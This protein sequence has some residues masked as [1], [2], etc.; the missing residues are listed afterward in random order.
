MAPNPSE[1]RG[2]SVGMLVQGMLAGFSAS[3]FLF[4]KI[5]GL[6]DD[7]GSV[8]FVYFRSQNPRSTMIANKGLHVSTW[9]G[10]H[11]HSDSFKYYG[12]K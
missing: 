3:P 10:Y 2:L 12:R 5:M 9:K 8:V 7:E 11:G 1:D 6:T 4:M